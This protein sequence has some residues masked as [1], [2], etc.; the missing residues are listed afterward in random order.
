MNV[1]GLRGNFFG[2]TLVQQKGEIGGARDVFV[3]LGGLKND[4][5]F[6]TFGGRVMNPFKGQAK[7]YAGD[8]IEYRT[9]DKGVSPEIYLLKTYQVAKASSSETTIQIVRDGY[10][11]RPFVGDVLM[12]APDT[13]DGT[14]AAYTVTAVS[15][16]DKGGDTSKESVWMVT[17]NTT[18]GELSKGDV[19]VEAK[20]ENASGKM[21]VQNV[22]AV[23]PC[24]YDFLHSDPSV[25]SD[26]DNEFDK[27]R[28][29]MTP[30]LGGLMYKHKMS[31]IPPCVEK[32]CNE[33]KVNGW[34][35]FGLKR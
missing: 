35:G 3:K 4:L 29:Y 10:K 7:I 18:L 17:L 16:S 12:K 14:G 15:T 5:I 28:Y 25:P 33:V 2:R 9:N 6:P 13:M 34:F 23:A 19:L 1:E 22:N 31:P 8:L 24:D 27:A 32:D 30:A 26:E 21:M 11:H 20:S